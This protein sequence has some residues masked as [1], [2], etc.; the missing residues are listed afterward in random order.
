MSLQ[1]EDTTL[2]ESA[3]L[4]QRLAESLNDLLEDHDISSRNAIRYK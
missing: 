2:T 1:K 3:V 4:C